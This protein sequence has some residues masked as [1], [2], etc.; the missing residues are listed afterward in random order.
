[1]WIPHFLSQSQGVLLYPGYSFGGMGLTGH[2][3][4]L[5]PLFPVTWN[6]YG[7][8]SPQYPLIHF[9]VSTA[10]IFLLESIPFFLCKF[11]KSSFILG[12]LCSY[13]MSFLKCH[14]MVQPVTCSSSCGLYSLSSF[15]VL[16][17]SPSTCLNITLRVLLRGFP[18]LPWPLLLEWWVTSSIPVLLCPALDVSLLVFPI[19]LRD[20]GA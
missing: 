11:V 17:G 8:L 20:V 18:S 5:P 14:W 9:F 16:W 2:N 19:V 7:V 12:S 10:D 1:M 6:T 3:C 13:S 15:L 4:N